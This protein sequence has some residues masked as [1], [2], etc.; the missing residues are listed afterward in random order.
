MNNILA[1]RAPLRARLK[2]ASD[3]S[4]ECFKIVVWN[5]CRCVLYTICAPVICCAI[6]CPHPTNRNRRHRA[7]AQTQKPEFPMPRRRALSLPL[8]GALP[9]QTTSHQ[10]YSNFMTKLYV[11]PVSVYH[12]YLFQTHKQTQRP[13]EIRR[14][15]YQEVLG[16]VTIHLK[17][18]R[19]KPS[20]KKCGLEQWGPCRCHYFD[21]MVDKKLAFGLGLLTTCRV[22]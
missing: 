15:I 20:A 8:I 19:G 5:T 17:T 16:G 13:L 10:P 1:Q 12:R 9:T 3:A 21:T 4:K 11:I 2:K 7:R 18:C 14:M 22:M 6:I